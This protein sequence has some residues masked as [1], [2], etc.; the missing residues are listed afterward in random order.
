MKRKMTHLVGALYFSCSLLFVKSL[1]NVQ[2]LGYRG[3]GSTT[4]FQVKAFHLKTEQRKIRINTIRQQMTISDKTSVE[5]CDDY[6]YDDELFS[7][8]PMMGHTN[9]HYRYFFRLVSSR[10]HLYTEMIPSKQIWAAYQRA[11]DLY[12]PEKTAA[13]TKATPVVPPHPE[14]IIEVLTRVI[15]DPSLEYH[16]AAVAGDLRL[17]LHQLLATSSP[18]LSCLSTSAATGSIRSEQPVVLQLGGNDPTALA[19]ASAIGAAWGVIESSLSLTGDPIATPTSTYSSINLNC[20]CPSNA[21]RGRSGGCA[22]METP[23]LVARC[24]E[25]MKDSIDCLFCNLQLPKNVM[26]PTIT[27][28]HRLGVREASTFDAIGDRLKN[29]DKTVDEVSSFIRTVSLSGK[30]QKQI[31]T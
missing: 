14:E 8:A 1:N 19:A 27:V 6:N 13:S 16:A 24:V 11:V 10:S 15:A 23:D 30:F 9:R 3:R 26:P 7:V 4:R 17:T 31:H 29:D 22:L 25:A 5:K 21:V 12:F 18:S 28:K 20:G 2:I